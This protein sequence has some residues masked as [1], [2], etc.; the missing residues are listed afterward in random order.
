GR[1]TF[2]APIDALP[3]TTALLEAQVTVRMR[4]TGGRAVERRT[5][6]M[7]RPE[8]SVIGI[9]PDAAGEEIRE[10]SN[11]GFRIMAVSPEGQRE[12][13]RGARWTLTKLDRNYQWYRSDNAWSYEAI[14]TESRVDGGSVDI[15][16]DEPASLSVPVEWGRYRLDVEG[17]GASGP[18]AS[19]VFNAGWFVE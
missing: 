16:T 10:N 6:V 13:L 15:G 5:T 12:A 1:S 8:E 17:T 18:V 3:Y 7:I 4:E 9:R 19:Y 14:E 2:S 11:A